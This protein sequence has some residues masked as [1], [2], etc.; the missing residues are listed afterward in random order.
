[1]IEPNFRNQRRSVSYDTSRPRSANI[2]SMSR[3][4]SVKRACS[5]IELVITSGGKR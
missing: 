5:Q 1:M 3:R 4:L 2:S